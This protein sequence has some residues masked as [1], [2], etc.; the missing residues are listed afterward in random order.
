MFT[1]QRTVS[2]PESPGDL[3]DGIKTKLMPPDKSPD[4]TQESAHQPIP[5]TR[6]T[7]IGLLQPVPLG[8]RI[9]QAL[10]GYFS[11]RVNFIRQPSRD[12]DD[13]IVHLFVKR[14]E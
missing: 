11:L 9:S 10:P 4:T 1:C 6:G 7:L 14:L 13:T 3:A 5:Q 12:V 2:S 8:L